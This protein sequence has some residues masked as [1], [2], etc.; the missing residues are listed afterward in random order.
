M[1]H[2]MINLINFLKSSEIDILLDK[3]SSPSQM[4]YYSYSSD[5]IIRCSMVLKSNNIQHHIK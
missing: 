4:I 2:C 3:M 1:I 5:K